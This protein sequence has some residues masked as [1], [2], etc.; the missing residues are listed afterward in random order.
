M[1]EV[2][3]HRT[4]RSL[5][6]AQVIALVGTG[7]L[8]VALGLLA[9]DLAG[10]DAGL[11]LG[12]ALTIKMVAYVGAAPLVAALVDRLPRKAVLVGADLVR[13]IAALMLP[14][15]TE[16]WQI[17]T[18][19]FVLQCASA[20]FTPAFQS[21]IPSVLP[22]ARDYTRALALSRLAYDLEALLSPVLA[23]ALLLV[24][25]PTNLFLGTALGFAVSAILVL[26]TALPARDAA[27]APSS[28][29]RRLP[30]GVRVFLRTPSLWFLM[31]ANLVVAAGAA[32]VLVDSVVYVK[33]ALALGDAALALTFGAYGA[34]SLLVAFAIPR[35]VDRVGVR[36]TMTAGIVVVTVG[37][38][39]AVAVSVA[40]GVGAMAWGLLLAAWAALG[41]GTSLVSTPSAHLVA[42]ASTP[43]NR[44]LVF[45]AQFALSH[46]CFLVAYPIAGWLGAV[47]LP[48]AAAVLC[49]VAIVGGAFAL[50]IPR[51]QRAVVPQE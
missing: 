4:Y 21:L 36:A 11:V 33:A 34:G 5:F 8:T 38:L 3:R 14:F 7:L 1:I 15:V 44:T 23:A 26:V 50:S 40:I 20:M 49:G 32:L 29:W 41:A 46:A 9:F 22:E 27:A 35:V 48:L 31:C 18:L 2:L 30:A 13:L 10:A 47:S 45:T 43:E 39:A 24:L 19:V 42:D 25:A 6:A 16:T 51:W 12:T 17:Y 37:L 28:F